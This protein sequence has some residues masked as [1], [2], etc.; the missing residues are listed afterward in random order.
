MKGCFLKAE[1]GVALRH[2]IIHRWKPHKLWYLDN[3]LVIQ[4]WLIFTNW[5]CLAYLSFLST[6]EIILEIM[7]VWEKLFLKQFFYATGEFLNIGTIYAIQYSFC[8]RLIGLW[9]KDYSNNELGEKLALSPL[10]C[11]ISKK[12]AHGWVVTSLDVFLPPVRTLPDGSCFL[13]SND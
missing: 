7:F 6:L 9:K 5:L 11:G 10:F 13:S 1:F 2:S 3:I 4:L 8:K 12:R